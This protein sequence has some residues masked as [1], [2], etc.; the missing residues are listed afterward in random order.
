[1]KMNNTYKYITNSK[2][3]SLTKTPLKLESLDPNKVRVK[4][5]YVS[6]A[7][8]DIHMIDCDW[9]AKFKEGLTPGHEAIGEIIDIG[10]DVP[11][12]YLGKKVG[13][14]YQQSACFRCET[15]A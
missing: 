2:K 1:M 11:K 13:L 6:I 12:S 8:G 3:G 5:S 10:Q 9:G 14:G 7:R 15:C 4:I